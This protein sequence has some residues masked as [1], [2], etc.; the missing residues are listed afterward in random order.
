MQMAFYDNTKAFDSVGGRA[1]QGSWDYLIITICFIDQQ[2]L[3]PTVTTSQ[4]HNTS[5]QYIDLQK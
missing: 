5:H 1:G 2:A 4:P 3:V